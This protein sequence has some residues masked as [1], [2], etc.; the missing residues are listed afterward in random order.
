MDIGTAKPSSEEL[1]RLPHHLI[2]VRSPDEQFNAGDFVRMADEAC[3]DIYRRG[4]LP[5]VS[6]GAGFYLSNFIKGLPETPPSDLRIRSALQDELAVRGPAFLMEELRAADPVSAGRIHINDTYRLTRAL[7]VFR[8]GGRPL[9]SYA[10]AADVSAR[11]YRFLVIGLR[12]ERS[13]LYRRI[14][15]RCAAMFRSGLAGEVRRLYEAGFSPGDPGLKA[16]GYREFF[17]EAETAPK[18]MPCAELPDKPDGAS[19]KAE[20]PGKPDGGIGGRPGAWRLCEDLAAVET[21][22]ARN[23]RH[24][25]KRQITWFSAVPGV[26]WIDMSGDPVKE[27]REKIKNI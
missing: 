26:S 5:V 2:D 20:L 17:I 27:I 14:N 7:E 21:L 1:K 16:I 13:E 10:A 4:K 3:A 15:E 6:G 12:R 11:N 19:P 9:S 24:Y 25:A 8:S 22:V 23:S 18:A